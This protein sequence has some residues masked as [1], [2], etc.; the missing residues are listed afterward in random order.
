[1]AADDHHQSSD[2]LVVPFLFVPDGHMPPA[3][4]LSRHPGAIRMRATL[5]PR[6]DGGSEVVVHAEED[7]RSPSTTIAQS[8]PGRSGRK[9]ESP[10]FSPDA[11]DSV[12][13]F[14]GVQA[15]FDNPG[16]AAG[17]AG[18]MDGGYT[19]VADRRKWPYNSTAPKRPAAPTIPEAAARAGVLT[20][21]VGG[22]GDA[23][24][25]N[26]NEFYKNYKLT[27]PES[28]YFHWDQSG[29]ISALI[30]A[31]P[32]GMK[33][34]LVGHSYGGD[35]AAAVAARS[36]RRI[37]KL[38][39]VD[40]VSHVSPDLT[41]VREHVDMWV[42]VVARPTDGDDSSDLIAGL[43]GDWRNRPAGLATRIIEVDSH[44]ADF[45]KLMTA[46]AQ[47]GKSALQALEDGR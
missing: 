36:P 37:D 30:A 8:A 33:I 23:T 35:T 22:A 38:I 44:H 17:L 9:S 13:A 29:E 46:P 7:R 43:G 21:F 42:D 41:A 16:H 34:N 20:I 27:H 10:E 11:R 45:R 18:A 6:R 24:F 1:M 40:P 32:P 12:R 39:T 28:I 26:V 5:V 31:A 14:A 4:W 19:N 15:V 25:N 3:D 2:V 47:D